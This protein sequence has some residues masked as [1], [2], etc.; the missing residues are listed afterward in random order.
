MS[1]EPFRL[2]T[3]NAFP[4][5]TASGRIVPETVASR[6]SS[7]RDGKVA[8]DR[9]GLRRRTGGSPRAGGRGD[10]EGLRTAGAEREG[11]LD[12]GDG[13][14]AIGVAGLFVEGDRGGAESLDGDGDG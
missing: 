3:F 1:T 5:A 4:G 6:A 9:R 11:D 12:G 8:G 13:Q 2:L 14:A 7:A 10:A